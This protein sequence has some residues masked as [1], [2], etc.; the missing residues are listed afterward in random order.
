M[1]EVPVVADFEDSVVGVIDPNE[2]EV[3]ELVAIGV[4]AGSEVTGGVVGAGV[5]GG[6]VNCD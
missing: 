5:L 6:E 4:A 1:A 2:P 3:A